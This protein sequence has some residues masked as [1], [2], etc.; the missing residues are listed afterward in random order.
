MIALNAAWH[1]LE[2]GTYTEDLEVWRQLARSAGGPVLDI[3]AGT[4]RTAIDLA[5]AGVTVTAV[6]MDEELLAVLRERAAGLPVTAVAAD[7]RTLALGQR[8]PLC[9]VPMQTAQLLGGAEGRRAFLER[10]REHLTPGGRLAVALAEELE[11]FEVTVPALGPLPD[12]R[13]IDGVVYSS[14]PTAVRADGDG[15]VL[16]RRR[17]AVWPDGR[18]V[19]GESAISLDRLDAATLESEGGAAGLTPAE[20]IDI[21]ATDEYVGS[22]VVVLCA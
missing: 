6:D 1:D 9:I 19:S 12:I 2:C 11:V 22:T 8:F 13:E 4:G 3:G 16:E 7:A 20:R 15:F 14:R 10:A 17:E 5:R 21:P 18:M